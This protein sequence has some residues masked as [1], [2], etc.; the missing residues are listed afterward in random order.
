MTFGYTFLAIY[1]T[2]S[3]PNYNNNHISIDYDW[4]FQAENYNFTH[5]YY[6][7]IEAKNA[8]EINR[9]ANFDFCTCALDA[10]IEDLMQEYNRNLYNITQCECAANLFENNLYQYNHRH[11]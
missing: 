2:N 10:W 8:Q 6:S 5:S 11:G 7:W 9:I 1:F 3:M 4:V